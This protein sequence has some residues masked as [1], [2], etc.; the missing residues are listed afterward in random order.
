MVA[1][2]LSIVP[3]FFLFLFLQK[4]FVSGILTGSVKQ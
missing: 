2:T 1:A 4:Q 3:I